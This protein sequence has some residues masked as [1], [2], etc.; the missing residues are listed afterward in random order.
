MDFLDWRRIG[1]YHEYHTIVRGTVMRKL[2]LCFAFL[3]VLLSGAFCAGKFYE[4][5]R[6]ILLPLSI[7]CHHAATDGYH[8][9]RFLET[10]QQEA[11]TFEQYL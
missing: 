6:K 2:L 3:L 9:H 11:D 4:Q 8:V 5:N 7:T 1:V 10:L